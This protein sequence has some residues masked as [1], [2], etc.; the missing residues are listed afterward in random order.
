MTILYN[1]VIVE[2]SVVFEVLE[3]ELGW[4]DPR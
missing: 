3:E 1:N 4:K 2:M